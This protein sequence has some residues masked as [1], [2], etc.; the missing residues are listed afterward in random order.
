MVGTAG[1]LLL[2]GCGGAQPKAPPEAPVEL[3]ALAAA[4]LTDVLPAVANAWKSH[5]GSAAVTFS[6]D[7]SSKLVRQVEAG[8]PADLLVTADAETLAAVEEQ[9]LL[10]PGSRR[11]L[12][13]NT[14]VVVVPAAAEWVPA[15]AADLPSTALHHLALAGENVPAGRYGRA[16]L[17]AAGV[18]PAVEARVVTGDNVRTTL[19]WVSRGEA[20]A[21]VVYATD[22]RGNPAVKVAFAFPDAS[23][24]P[25]VYPGAVIA[26]S[27]HADLAAAFL[28]FC[29]SPEGT[30]IFRDAG[31]TAPPGAK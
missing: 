18:M 19:A 11:E 29:S 13:G 8:V 26:G 3:V 4:S 12:L 21:G 14:L 22:A 20:E 30:A 10:V 17:S 23:H 16:S 9:G 28:A 31:F 24:P 1:V 25:I 6:F 27:G 7:S 2:L 15:S 5:P